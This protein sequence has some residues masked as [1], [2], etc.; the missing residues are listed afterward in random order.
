MISGD[1][2][3]CASNASRKEKSEGTHL[4]VSEGADLLLRLL[5]DARVAVSEVRHANC[6]G[7]S[8]S[9]QTRP[10][11]EALAVR[12]ESEDALPQVKSRMVRPHSVL[13]YEPLP[14]VMTISVKRPT[15]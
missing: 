1:S 6:R 14:S 3:R 15:L 7:I 13:R 10:A 4:A 5:G 12:G 2:L 9:A 11:C 8:T